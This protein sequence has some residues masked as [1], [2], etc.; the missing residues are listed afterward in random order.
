M[1][2]A[3]LRE[4]LQ[5][6]RSVYRRE[7][8]RGFWRKLL[9]RLWA[10]ALDVL[11]PAVL[12]RPRRSRRLIRQMLAEGGERVILWR[13]SFGWDAPL[14]QRPQ[15]IALALARSGSL[16]V[17]EVSRATDGVAALRRKEARLWLFNFSNPALRH[18]LLRE[19]RRDPRPKYLQLY[20]TDWQLSSAQLER[21]Q[22][23][24]FRVI[25]EYVDAI[26]PALSGTGSLPKNVLDKYRYALRH[27]DVYIVVTA[28]RLRLDVLARRGARRLITATNG[29]DFAYF[30]GADPAFRPDPAF[31]RVLE[32][33]RPVVC[34]YGAL[35]SWV[36]Y[37]LL[38]EIAATG[39]WSVVLFGIRYD[40]SFERE[41]GGGEDGIFF[42]GPRPYAQLRDYARRCDVMMIPFLIN[43]LTRATS[44]VKLFEYMALKKPVVTTDLDEC[45]RYPPVLIARS[46]A[47]FLSQL[48]RALTLR[49][50]AAYLARL[51]A[52][53]RNNDWSAKARAIV[54]ALK[55][56][57]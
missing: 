26:S 42:L 25:Y 15:H 44:P 9:T 16:V 45:R 55:R 8:F 22:R 51:E 13:S 24:G 48:E 41:L 19:L 38:R 28:E 36:D 3:A 10:R 40:D 11:S 2:G 30:S 18:W 12:L 39:R 32:R 57:E 50:D 35:A 43:D 4:K 52:E 5:K 37:A 7:G 29:V 34:Y 1:E 20:S 27:R 47:E 21:W 56:D 46:H 23:R 49:E 53:A 33:G 31:R 17:Y 54:E 6:L 14:Y